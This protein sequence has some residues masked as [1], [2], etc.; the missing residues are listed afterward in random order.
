MTDGSSSSSSRLREEAIQVATIE[1][2]MD[3]FRYNRER[4]RNLS[5]QVGDI[6][7]SDNLQELVRGESQRIGEENIQ[8]I[9]AEKLRLMEAA[10]SQEIESAKSSSMEAAQ[11]SSGVNRM[12]ESRQT[13]VTGESTQEFNTQIHQEKANRGSRNIDHRHETIMVES[14]LGLNLNIQQRGEDRGGRYIDSR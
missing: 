10:K 11:S 1:A 6:R 12:D 2:E 5:L 14:S 4:D 8:A 9:E 3:E 13:L 7:R